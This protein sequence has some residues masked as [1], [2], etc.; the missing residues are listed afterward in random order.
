MVYKTDFCSEFPD[1]PDKGGRIPKRK[2]SQ[3][4]EKR[5]AFQANAKMMKNAFHFILKP[6]FVLKIFKFSSGHFCHLEKTVWL[7]T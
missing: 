1:I 5:F 3:A 7:E 6:I 2:I 4:I